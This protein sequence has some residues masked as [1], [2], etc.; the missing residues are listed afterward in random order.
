MVLNYKKYT[1]SKSYVVSLFEGLSYPIKGCSFTE[2]AE[3]LFVL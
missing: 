2:H 3:E 1:S